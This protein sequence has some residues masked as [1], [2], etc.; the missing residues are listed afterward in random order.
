MADNP[1]RNLEEHPERSFGHESIGD[2]QL[3]V[4]PMSTPT[5]NLG[6]GG[7]GETE[8]PEHKDHDG[9]PLT[10]KA[11]ERLKD[12]VKDRFKQGLKRGGG[13]AAKKGAQQG[14]E[15][16]AE[17]ATGGAGEAGG[18]AGAGAAGAAGAGAAGASAGAGAAAGAAGAAAGAAGGAAGAAAGAGAG[19]GTAAVSAAAGTA[20]AAGAATAETGVGAVI[21]VAAAVLIVTGGVIIK[22]RKELAMLAVLSFIGVILLATALLNGLKPIASTVQTAAKYMSPVQQIVDN[23]TVSVLGR[24]VTGG[25]SAAVALDKSQKEH[26]AIDGSG[27]VLAVTTDGVVTQGKLKTLF[28]A[29]KADSFEEQIKEKYGLEFKAGNGS[30]QI[31]RYGQSLGDAHTA[32]EAESILREKFPDLQRLLSEDINGWSWAQHIKGARNMKGQFGIAQLAIPGA[33]SAYDSAQLTDVVKY[34]IKSMLQT[35]ITNMQRGVACFTGGDQCNELGARVPGGG[36]AVQQYQDDPRSSMTQATQTALDEN[37]KN[38][39]PETEYHTARLDTTA[40]KK[41]TEKVESDSVGL[42]GWLDIAAS[43]KEMSQ[44]KEAQQL[45]SILRG[46]QAGALFLWNLSSVNQQLGKDMTSPAASLISRNYNSIE[47]SQA[48][49]YVAYDDATR[50]QSMLESN[51][52]LSKLDNAFETVYQSMVIEN[53]FITTITNILFKAWLLVHDRLPGAIIDFAAGTPVGRLLDH[54]GAYILDQI[55]VLELVED[56]LGISSRALLPVCDPADKTYNFFNCIASGAHTAANYMCATFFGCS[57]ISLAQ[58]NELKIASARDMNARLAYMPF[59][60][61][62]FDQKVPNSFINVAAMNSPLPTRATNNVASMFQSV[63]S[64]VWSAPNKVASMAA[65]PARA[66]ESD[67]SLIDGVEHIGIPL[68]TILNTPLAIELS[69]DQATC[70]PSKIGEEVSMCLADVGTV[71]S[72]I[73]RFTY[74]PSYGS[75]GTGAVTAT[76]PNQ[77]GSAADL[78]TQI[79]ANKNIKYWHE[80]SKNDLQRTSRGEQVQNQCGG[81]IDIEKNLL[82]VINEAGKKYTFMINSLVSDH[83]CNAAYHPQGKAIDLDFVNLIGSNGVKA[84]S[85]SLGGALYKQFIIDL[86]NLSH[87]VSP[88][89]GFGQV[90][91]TGRIT[92]PAGITQANDACNHLHMSIG[93]EPG[94]I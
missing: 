70:Q 74:N 36:V 90:Q 35:G 86:A 93:G 18:A 92:L 23:R 45:P 81:N 88:T 14:A 24:F 51:K 75:S 28:D 79:L 1:L 63:F 37:I 85:G 40:G 77:V 60:K 91:C 19:A 69:Q 71:D 54:L 8:Q 80:G 52:I 55:G 56:I 41:V 17:A 94:K 66:A 68:P 43:T 67:E 49:N 76:D 44:K 65:A 42:L 46:K 13:D 6:G 34:Q 50:G 87:S 72:L 16:G 29:M 83:H 10:D 78:A 32:A 15:A 12:E 27:R 20:A 31:V 3:N 82:Y 64:A 4:G 84:E 5:G 48:Y 59:E 53:P 61:R 57:K 89:G 25:S 30:V 58:S 33:E 39:S 62:L 26:V 21:G 47:D 22:Y 73:G 7:G 9:N 38:I 11:E 2:G